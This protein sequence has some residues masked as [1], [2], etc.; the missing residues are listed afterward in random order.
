[1]TPKRPRR[2]N[3]QIVYDQ[4]Q[5]APFFSA[6]VWFPP[7]VIRVDPACV[8]LNCLRSGSKRDGDPCEMRLCVGSR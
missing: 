8:R 1:M 2:G 7:A 4:H 5:A 6:Q 3:P